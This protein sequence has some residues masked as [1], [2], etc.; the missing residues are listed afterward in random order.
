MP[1]Y[2]ATMSDRKMST[3]VR[4]SQLL[5][6]EVRT[7][8]GSGAAPRVLATGPYRRLSLNLSVVNAKPGQ[9]PLMSGSSVGQPEE[10]NCED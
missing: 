4:H 9:I 3:H 5:L 10:V 7:L 6:I 2:E 8:A 1:I